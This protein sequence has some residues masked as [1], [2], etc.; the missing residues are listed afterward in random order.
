M[1]EEFRQHPQVL[2][3]WRRRAHEVQA[4]DGPWSKFPPAGNGIRG[5]DGLQSRNGGL[6]PAP[7]YGNLSNL[8]H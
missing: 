6:N 7:L 8:R 1:A 3:L 4:T 5:R 2:A